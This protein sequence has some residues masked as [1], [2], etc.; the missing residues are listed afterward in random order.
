AAPDGES[1]LIAERT[2]RVVIVSGKGAAE[3]FLDLGDRVAANGI[4]QGLLGLAVHSTDS[5]VFF[6][7]ASGNR[8]LSRFGFDGNEAVTESEE[9]LFSLPQPEGSVDIRHYG[10]N[11][12]FGPD[13]YLYV[14]LGDGADA[15]GQGQD[16]GTVFGTILRLD[17]D[18]TDPY[19][20]PADNPLA[21]KGGAPEVWAYGLRNPW[22]FTIDPAESLLYVADVGQESWEEVNVLSLDEGGANLGWPS[23][24]GNRCFLDSDCHLADFAAPVVEYGHDEGCSITGGHVYRGPAIPELH[25]HYFYS[26]WCGG[27]LRSFRYQA[28]EATDLTDWSVEGAGQ[29][30]AFGVDPDGE[31]LI[32]NYA[33]EIH[34]IVPIR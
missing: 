15:R 2:G 19:G 21:Q 22:R 9:V 30:N 1:L 16:P 11:L 17:V 33:G 12:M 23:A 3:T 14:S 27:W 8:T 28:G 29:V 25:G 5:D 32:A 4:E 13:G 7:A 20:I 26:D 6:V 34:R 24:E 18:G 31:L 10:G